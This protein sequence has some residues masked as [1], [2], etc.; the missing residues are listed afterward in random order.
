MKF[1]RLTVLAHYPLRLGS[2]GRA[3]Y[4]ICVCVCGTFKI[5]TRPSLVDKNTKSCGCLQREEASKRHIKHG[6]SKSEIYRS[7]NSMIHRTTNPK[8]RDYKNYGGRGIG[9]CE[10]WLIFENFHKDMGPRLKGTTLE[11][12]DNN[13]GYSKENCRWATSK[14]QAYNKRNSRHITYKGETKN[15]REWA[16]QYKIQLGTLVKRI[17]S[18]WPIEKALTAPT[19]QLNLN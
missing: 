12:I 3:F 16:N 18:R 15:Y 9:I 14:E 19:R 6:M 1:N 17:E 7:W 11:R 4:Y 2:N 10:E 5:V 8:S 13:L